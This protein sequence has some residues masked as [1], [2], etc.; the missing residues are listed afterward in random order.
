[1]DIAGFAIIIIDCSLSNDYAAYTDD[2]VM[3]MAE[4]GNNKFFTEN[5][6]KTCF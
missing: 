4:H 6:R 2:Y 5:L 3:S 1:M